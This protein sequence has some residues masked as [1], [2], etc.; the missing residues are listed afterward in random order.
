MYD[1][2]K[3][4]TGLLIFLVLLTS[5]IW[6]NFALGKAG[7][8][9]QLKLGTKEKHCIEPVAYMRSSHMTL[10]NTWRD[11]VIRNGDRIYVAG[12]GRQYDIS[13]TNTC[14]K[15]HASKAEFCD[16]CHAYAA[17]QPYCW[18]CHNAPEEKKHETQ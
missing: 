3:I 15:C 17:V 8:V 1:K 12:D 6:Y 13:L 10:L 2:G 7:A 9:P 18:D 14:L 5:P 16:K 11:A 4:L